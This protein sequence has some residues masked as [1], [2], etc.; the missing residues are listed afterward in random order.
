MPSRSRPLVLVV[1]V[2]ALLAG[3]VV[4][5]QGWRATPSSGAPG[6]DGWVS[7]TTGPLGPADRDLVVRVRLAGLWE[8]PAGQEAQARATQP[9]VREIAGFIAQ[10]HHDLDQMTLAVA[11]ELG[12]LLP[13]QPSEQQQVWL[14]EISAQTGADY[15]R[16]MVNLLRQAHGQVLPLLA[17]VRTTTRNDT[18]RRFAEESTVYVT[19]HINYLESTGLVDFDALP[20]P[21]DPARAVVTPA[22]EYRNVP[23]ALLALGAVLVCAA[24]FGLLWRLVPR[25][26]RHAR[27]ARLQ[28]VAPRR[29][30]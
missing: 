13:N 12:V 26:P 22:G 14:S 16:T 17:Q 20:Q 1:C 27:P 11:K 28:S 4:L 7:T 23:V 25:R 15:D 9:R 6:Q 18:V 29:S 8:M 30:A 24:L 10:E 5:W 2:A 19:R 3:V 21:P